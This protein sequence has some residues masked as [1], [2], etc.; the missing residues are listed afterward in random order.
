VTGE[1]DRSRGSSPLWGIGLLL[2]VI[3]ALSVLAIVRYLHFRQRV[4][5]TAAELRE[6]VAELR[7]RSLGFDEEVLDA[8]EL[9]I[10]RLEADHLP[11]LGW[12]RPL[13]AFIGPA[14]EGSPGD[15]PTLTLYWLEA[16]QSTDGAVLETVSE[17][18]DER[19]TA[20]VARVTG[21]ANALNDDQVQQRYGERFDRRT[22]VDVKLDGGERGENDGPVVH[23]TPKQLDSSLTARLI[24]DSDT[25]DPMPVH[26]VPSLLK[27]HEAKPGNTSGSEP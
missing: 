17:S 19:E 24:Y 25:T 21:W 26:V 13:F 2:L 9:Q 3:T 6:T 4:K 10:D 11:K 22:T 15:G 27:E 12:P 23:L 14:P 1:P 5:D 20:E 8:F 7:S 16:G 18:E